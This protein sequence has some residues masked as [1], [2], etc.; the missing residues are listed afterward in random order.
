MPP[1]GICHPLVYAT[2]WYMP[3]WLTMLLLPF[4]YPYPNHLMLLI[5]LTPGSTASGHGKLRCISV[6][7]HTVRTGQ[8]VPVFVTLLLLLVQRKSFHFGF[9][10]TRATA[11]CNSLHSALL[12]TLSSS[13]HHPGFME[14][15]R[16][17][18]PLHSWPTIVVWH[19]E[20]NNF[21]F[22]SSNLP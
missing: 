4:C 21:C 11:A 2:R 12:L 9:T 16:L 20:S 18:V 7:V 1:A 10:V 19:R 5:G 13:S 3:P 6:S 17:A 8:V 14:P 22:D 15:I